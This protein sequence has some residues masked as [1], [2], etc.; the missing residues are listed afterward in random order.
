M[1]VERKYRVWEIIWEKHDFLEEFCGEFNSEKE[2]WKYVFEHVEEWLNDLD[3]YS[4]DTQAIDI[5]I[6]TWEKDI[7]EQDN[8]S[9]ELV[10]F[11][12]AWTKTKQN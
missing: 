7:S 9:E 8:S 11:I 1:L 12:I 5:R 2:A 10:D 3:T 6:D 4:E